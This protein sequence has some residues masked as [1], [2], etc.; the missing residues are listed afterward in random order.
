MHKA[1]RSIFRGDAG[2]V[3]ADWK[4]E[5][6]RHG[7]TIVVRSQKHGKILRKFIWDGEKFREK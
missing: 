6:P 4:F 5:L 2:S 1:P 7:R 3:E